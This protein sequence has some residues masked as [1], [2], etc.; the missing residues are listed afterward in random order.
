[1]NSFFTNIGPKLAEQCNGNGDILGSN[2]PEFY[3]DVEEVIYLCRQIEPLK[4]LGIDELSSK[5]CKDAFF[6][7]A[8]KLTH[9]FNC[10]LSQG[11]FPDE[12]KVAK[13]I[14][15][16]KG[17]DREQ[18]G[19]Y[20]PISLLLLPGKLLEKIVHKRFVD[21]FDECGFL[22]N[23]QGGY[24]KGF[25]TV[26]TIA[27]L[28]DDLFAEINGVNTTIAAF[29]DL[30]KAFDT[31]NIGILLQK[32]NKAGIRNKTL[33]WCRSYLSNRAQRTYPP[34]L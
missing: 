12:W 14:T 8:G 30:K 22:S 16:F 18:L 31:V 28:T 32:L 27:E 19:N 24:R 6:G 4:S 23:Y 17:G 26:S 33:D 11:I 7:A 21:F 3:T 25:S 1:M 20:R 15:L 34:T 2:I 13:V 5:T 9:I 10:S 29:I